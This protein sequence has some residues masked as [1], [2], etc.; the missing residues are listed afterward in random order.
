[1]VVELR[2]PKRELRVAGNRR[3]A[4]ALVQKQRLNPWSDLEAVVRD[5]NGMQP[6]Q[7]RTATKFQDADVPEGTQL[8]QLVGEVQHTVH[9]CVLREES[10]RALGVGQQN[11]CALGEIRQGLDLVQE[12]LEFA[13]GWRRFLRGDQAV[14]DQQRGLVLLDGAANQ[15][16]QPSSPSDARTL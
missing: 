14:D 12:L 2:H 9:H 10:A 13:I 4:D 1:M 8:G 5:P 3:L 7:R 6:A 15:G 11:H 16:D